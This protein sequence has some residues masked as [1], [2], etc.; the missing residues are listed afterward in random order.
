M[1]LGLSLF[2]LY[3]GSFTVSTLLRK[4]E[5]N[6]SRIA[7]TAIALLAGFGGAV[8]LTH[9]SGS[10]SSAVG[11]GA[12]VLGLGYYGLAFA[13]SEL[14]WGY[15]RN[16][17]YCAWL[18]F[19]LTLSGFYLLTSGLPVLL[20]WSVL[21][22]AAAVAGSHFDRT[23]LFDHSA[24]YAVAA[25]FLAV[26]TS[27]GLIAFAIDTFT[28]PANQPWP[29]IS[30]PELIVIGVATSSF[31]VIA[32]AKADAERLSKSG[33]PA[34]ALAVVAALGASATVVLTLTH[35]LGNPPPEANAAVV[36]A[37]RTGVIAGTVVALAAV[38]RL[39]GCLE[40]RWLVY[41]LFVVGGLKLFLEDLP[42]GE[43]T[44]QML[45]FALYGIALMLAP[46][47]V[48]ADREPGTVAPESQQG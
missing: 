20:A 44:T 12:L 23:T 27:H 16:H 21:S 6:S 39:T 5:L 25:A 37:V 7:Q 24:A 45:A 9:T 13:V 46:R 3:A 48:R 18:A 28:L 32:L 38:S 26:D 40:L 47:L 8:Y 36:A 42:N 41:L 43:P 29:G 15:R 17:T 1:L 14:H 34:L 11:A 35:A 33:L 31:M 2:V 30:T 10:G 22:V 4:R 19:I